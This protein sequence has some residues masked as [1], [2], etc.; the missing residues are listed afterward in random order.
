MKI[1]VK[2]HPRA[3]RNRLTHDGREYK[4]EVTAPPVDGKA[5]DA[6]I[7]FFARG[8]G[9]PRAAVCILTGSHS[10]RKVVEIA[11]VEESQVENLK[12]EI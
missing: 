3:R 6:V 5:N 4:L 12:S 9:L 1:N 11:G 2:V 8:L 7:D 10:R